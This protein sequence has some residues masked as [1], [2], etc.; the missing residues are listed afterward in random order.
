MDK[1]SKELKFSEDYFAYSGYVLVER[2]FR[3]QSSAGLIIPASAKN[4][5]FSF[6][7]DV[8]PECRHGIQKGDFLA[9]SQGT[10]LETVGPNGGQLFMVPENMIGVIIPKAAPW[11]RS[12]V[13]VD[14]APSKSCAAK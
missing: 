10:N 1:D 6:V 11:P 2:G 5:K 8:G 9:Y 7:L 14:S 3:T 12:R 13:V 4:E